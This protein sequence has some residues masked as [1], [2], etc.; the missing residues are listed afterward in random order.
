[1]ADRLDGPVLRSARYCTDS[2]GFSATALSLS[3][4]EH[5][6]NTYIS[7]AMPYADR[8]TVPVERTKAEIEQTLIDLELAAFEKRLIDIPEV[9]TADASA[10]VLSAIGG[11]AVSEVELRRFRHCADGRGFRTPI[12]HRLN[13]YL[14]RRTFDSCRADAIEGHSG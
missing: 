12:N 5:D 11:T 14:V 8:T 4:G 3:K 13:P 10:A 1:V 9:A 6:T 7:K 2:R